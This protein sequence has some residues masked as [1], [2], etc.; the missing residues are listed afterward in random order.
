[1]EVTQTMERAMLGAKRIE[2]K[3]ATSI[4]GANIHTDSIASSITDVES[5]VKWAMGH[6]T[7]RKWDSKEPARV[8]SSLIVKQVKR[9][10]THI[11]RVWIIRTKIGN[12]SLIE[13]LLG[14]CC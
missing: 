11:S 13:L 4:I 5:V 14:E 10:I 6:S 8:K 7:V 2:R 12:E 1:M 3:F 9:D